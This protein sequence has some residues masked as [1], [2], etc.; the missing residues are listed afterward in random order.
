MLQRANVH[1]FE[2]RAHTILRMIAVEP[3][4]NGDAFAAKTAQ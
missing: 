1:A 4:E 2:P 3:G